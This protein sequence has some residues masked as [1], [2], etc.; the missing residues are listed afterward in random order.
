MYFWSMGI[1]LMLLFFEE[2]CIAL[3]KSAGFWN[4]GFEQ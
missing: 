2:I 4:A 1:I 3:R